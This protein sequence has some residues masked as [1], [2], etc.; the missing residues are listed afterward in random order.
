MWM[1]LLLAQFAAGG[2]LSGVNVGVVITAPT[3]ASSYNA[4]TASTITVSGTSASD[5]TITGCTWSDSLGGSGA[6]TG[7]TTWSILSLALTV[8]PNVITVI[9]TNIVGTTSQASITITRTSGSS[10]PID[11]SRRM[12]WS[13]A[14]IPGG[15]PTRTTICSTLGTAGQAPSFN[16]SSVTSTTINNAVSTCG[17]DQVVLLNPGTYTLSTGIIVQRSH[18]VLRGFGANQTILNFTGGNGCHGGY[19]SFVNMCITPTDNNFSTGPSNTATWTAGFTQGSTTIT[20]SS[21]TNLKVGSLLILDQTDDSAV[22]A[23]LLVCQDNGISP[24]CSLEG[25]SGAQRPSREQEQ[26][27]TVASCDGNSTTGHACVSGATVGITP[28]LYQDNW[29]SGKTPGAWWASN[30]ITLVG[31]ED[32]TVD[33]SGNAGDKGIFISDCLYCW[34]RGLRSIDSGK[35]HIEIVQSAHSQVQDNYLFLTQSS[36]S[37]SYGVEALSASDDLY[38]NNISQYVATPWMINGP[39]TGCVVAYNFSINN[40]YTASAHYNLPSTNQHTAG[41]AM[42]LYEGN[43]GGMF[44]A[45]VFHGTHNMVTSFRNRWAGTQPACWVSGSYPTITFGACTGQLIT[46]DLHSY[47]RYY[48]IVGDV[49]GTAG[50]HNFYQQYTGG[51]SSGPSIYE[52]GFGNSESGHPTVLPDTLVL[53][54]LF[55]WG[56]WD[57]VSN[58]VRWCGNA[59]NTGWVIG[60]ASTTEVPSGLSAYANPIPSTETLPPSEFLNAMPA[61]WPVAKPW[62]PIGP[63]VTGGNIAGTGGHAYTLPAQDCYLNIIGGPADGTGTVLTFNRTTCYP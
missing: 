38:I 46:H 9:C 23:G 39:C 18:L 25:N 56:N 34:V 19:G 1:L 60:C 62:P 57:A 50:V 5:R 10:N 14:G 21:V 44:S 45:D 41:T 48:N 51:P 36:A 63:E 30:P 12:D 52:I 20:L 27:V 2:R 43:V 24:P 4:G 29:S 17:T 37:Q 55:R 16:Q 54:T 13:A 33:Y 32:L 61:W 3:T 11:A 15:I 6:T 40:L 7:T 31:V 42:L 49:L 53:A 28:G 22:G 59:L 47:S 35:A 8:G 58:A 26:I